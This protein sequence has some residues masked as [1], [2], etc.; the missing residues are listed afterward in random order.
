MARRRRHAARDQVSGANDLR[1]SLGFPRGEAVRT[2]RRRRWPGRRE[3]GQ[4]EDRQAR[5]AEKLGSDRARQRR[6]HHHQNSNRRR[7]REE[8]RAALRRHYF[9]L[10]WRCVVPLGNKPMAK[11][12]K[13]KAHASGETSPPVKVPPI[14]AATVEYEHWLRERVGVVESDL[15]QKYTQ[16]RKQPFAFL[17]ATFYR[18]SALW[19]KV[20]P[21]LAEAPELLAMGDLH[22][23]N[24]GTW[25]DL[26]GRLVWG[27]NDFDEVAEMPY[28]IDLVRLV[29][30][31]ILAKRQNELAIDAEHAAE[32][33]LE[34]YTQ[35]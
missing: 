31:V 28:T 10:S 18:W 15:R 6:G 25:R 11:S 1:D 20:C 8:K 35:W 3:L 13:T 12:K 5:T 29:T 34:G 30:S 17:R 33:V 7:L 4:T 2:S 9:A 23:E 19:P 27:I 24:F 26:E 21:D 22:V 14:V 32:A 16:M